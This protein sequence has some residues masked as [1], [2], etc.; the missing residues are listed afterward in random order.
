MS[1]QHLFKF[2]TENDYK[3]AKRNHLLVP[4]VS[5]IVENGNIYIT[6][7]FATKET[8]EAGDIIVYHIESNGEKTI[9]Y[10]KPEAFDPNDEYWKADSIVVVP[11]SHTNDGTV[12]AMGKNFAGTESPSKGSDGQEIFYGANASRAM[13]VGGGFLV[14]TNYQNQTID[15]THGLIN[16]ETPVNIASDITTQDNIN[17]YDN[18][19]AYKIS[20]NA[21]FLPSPYL[22]NGGKNPA[23]HSINAFE[24]Y[25][26]NIL[27]NMNGDIETHSILKNMGDN[28]TYYT[29]DS[30]VNQESI[31]GHDL[32]PAISASMRYNS[33]LKPCVFDVN[34]TIDDNIATMPWYLPSI[35]EVGYLAA[36][37]NKIMYAF[38]KINN[39]GIQLE[40][41]KIL[42]SSEVNNDNNKM[43]PVY[44]WKLQTF[45]LVSPKELKGYVIPFVKF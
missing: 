19:T 10:M 5:K 20:D 25:N 26:T 41:V 23:Y 12:R 11:F 1:E 45:Q 44:D 33:V 14:F 43:V 13:R 39:N 32:C 3:I 9:K 34:N 30:L 27:K 37:F 22:N 40:P 16:N 31:D 42:T 24:A 28:F 38:N 17:P 6:P 2:Q 18:E 29:S 35:G 8:A 4:N 21:Q 36:R 7:K 15:D